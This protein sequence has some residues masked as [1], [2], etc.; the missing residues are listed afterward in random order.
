MKYVF[1]S[2]MEFLWSMQVDNQKQI[3]AWPMH[4]C[5]IKKKFMGHE[6]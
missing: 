2:F 4:C 5:S 6:N 3:F 1:V